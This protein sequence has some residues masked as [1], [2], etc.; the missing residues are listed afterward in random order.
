MAQDVLK[1]AEDYPPQ[2][3]INTVWAAKNATFP[4]KQQLLQ[5]VTA[6]AIPRLHAF[7]P[8]ELTT[9]LVACNRL[10]VAHLRLLEVPLPHSFQTVPARQ[11]AP[12]AFH[13]IIGSGLVRPRHAHDDMRGLVVSPPVVGVATSEEVRLLCRGL[14]AAARLCLERFSSA[15]E[16][17]CTVPAPAPRPWFLHKT[18]LARGAIRPTEEA[19]AGGCGATAWR[20]AVS[21]RPSRL[22]ID[23]TITAAGLVRQRHGTLQAIDRELCKP[24]RMQNL[25]PWGAAAC[26]NAGWLVMRS[27]RVTS[28]PRLPAPEGC[29]FLCQSRNR[30]PH[31][32]LRGIV[33]ASC[34]T[35]TPTAFRRPSVLCATSP[36]FP[37]PSFAL[38]VHVCACGALPSAATSR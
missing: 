17:A 29:W 35:V 33:H 1:R 15:P 37:L 23:G 3:L 32:A 16:G 19:P 27:A 24:E 18:C 36:C 28:A 22:L 20:A 8:P 34:L 30:F 26:C 38:L 7:T 14:E 13:V 31:S 5:R 4:S 21:R 12:G 6:E 25:S 9:L 10:G 2:P 11:R